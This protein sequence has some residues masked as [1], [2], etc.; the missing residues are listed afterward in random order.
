MPRGSRKGKTVFRIPKFRSR[1]KSP[2]FPP[3]TLQSWFVTS[4]CIPELL[5]FG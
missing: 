2:H 4:A 3:A 5:D 1:L